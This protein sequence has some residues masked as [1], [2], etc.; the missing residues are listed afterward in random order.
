MR[1]RIKSRAHLDM[2]QQDG[3]VD[4]SMVRALGAPAGLVPVLRH[5]NELDIS[6]EQGAMLVRISSA[7]IDRRPAAAGRVVAISLGS[8]CRRDPGHQATGIA[9]V[10]SN[11][12][13][14]RISTAA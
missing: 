3:R 5:L 10:D 6:D 9:L 8:A 4:S 12:H 11:N 2:M 7:T 13:Q 1:Q 14:N